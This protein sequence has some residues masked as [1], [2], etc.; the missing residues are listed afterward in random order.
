MGW[1]D[2]WM[3]LWLA[4]CLIQ[5]TMTMT[6]WLLPVSLTISLSSRIFLTRVRARAYACSTSRCSVELKHRGA[7][8][9]LFLFPWLFLEDC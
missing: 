9:F 4:D 7:C 5:K 1:V 6:I 2:G 3:V 8:R